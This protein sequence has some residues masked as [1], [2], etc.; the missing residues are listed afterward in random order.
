MNAVPDTR[1]AAPAPILSVRDLTVSFAR[2][3]G[4]RF[5]V[6]SGV[7]FDIQPHE[8]VGIVGESGSGKSMT[9][10]SLLGIVPRGGAVHGSILFRGHD[11]IGMA[12]QELRKLRGSEM[13]MIFQDPMTSL[14]PVLRVGD[15]I[16]EAVALH[17][18]RQPRRAIMARVVS[19]LQR[20]GISA[21]SERASAY[22][23]EFSGGMRQRALIAMGIAN[24]PVLLV[25]DEPT[26]ALD[27]TVQDQ[28]LDLMRDLNA[29]NGTAILMITHN[30]AVVASLCSR[31]IVMYA[32]RVVEDGPAAQLLTYATHPYTWSLLNSVPRPEHAGARLPAIAGHPPDP[33]NIPHGCT[34]APRCPRARERCFER[35]PSLDERWPDHRVRCWFP[36]GTNEELGA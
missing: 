16:G 15:Q 18:A 22:P 21:A 17:G 20:V 11:I 5:A 1:E 4:S 25:A 10:R 30:I 27:V 24:E 28:I 32:G 35:E 31:V 13:A 29:G 12:D 14:N 9:A 33:A 36:I 3:D 7:D 6:V 34:F 26:T 8:I 2:R 19:L 23:H